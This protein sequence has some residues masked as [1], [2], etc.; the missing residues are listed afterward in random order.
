[1]AYNGL[2]YRGW[3]QQPTGATVQGCM[4]NRLR[5]IFKIPVTCVGCGRTD[6]MVHASQFFAHIDIPFEWDFDLLFRINKVLPEDISVFDIIPVED[7]CN[8]RFDATQRTY[9]YFIHDY[10]DPFLFGKSAQYQFGTLDFESM[11]KATDLLREYDNYKSFC[12]GPNRHNTTFSHVTAAQWF[13][14]NKGNRLRFQISADRFLHGMIRILVAKL[15][16][17]GQGKLSLDAFRE[18][19]TSNRE[20][21][22]FRPAY[23]Q[24]LYLSKV[25]Y[26]YLDVEPRTEFM[27]MMQ[28]M[29]TW[30]E[31]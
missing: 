29:A 8:V 26:P 31:I 30:N 22:P 7:W 11:R 17:V 12:L 19:F 23:A 25:T 2:N 4:E 6:A 9:D 24:G 28:G 15:L 18:M 13:V 10:K 1:M 27:D 16:L 5:R 21:E 14:G 3:Q 20:P